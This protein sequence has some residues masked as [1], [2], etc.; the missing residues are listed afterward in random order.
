MPKISKTASLWLKKVL[1]GRGA[2]E[3]LRALRCYSLLM[4]SSVIYPLRLIKSMSQMY[5]L[6]KFFA[7]S[8][9]YKNPRFQDNINA[10]K[11]LGDKRLRNLLP[12]IF[13]CTEDQNSVYILSLR[14]AKMVSGRK[15]KTAFISPAIHSPQSSQIPSCS[16]AQPE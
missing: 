4:S 7:I 6:K 11:I 5:L 8:Y 2:P 12:D 16:P 3:S 9:L 10:A 14:P 15:L 1:S 13:H